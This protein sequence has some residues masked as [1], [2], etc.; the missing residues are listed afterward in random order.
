LFYSLKFLILFCRFE[1]LLFAKLL[2]SKYEEEGKFHRSGG[3]TET[4]RLP[5]K[6]DSFQYF[7]PEERKNATPATLRTKRKE[8]NSCRGFLENEVSRESKSVLEKIAEELIR[9]EVLKCIHNEELS[10]KIDIGTGPDPEPP[11]FETPL[12]SRQLSLKL[13]TITEEDI[14]PTPELTPPPR[15]N[16]KSAEVMNNA[17]NIEEE[18]QLLTLRTP[19]ITPPR[20]APV[21][22]QTSKKTPTD[23]ND[24]T[25]CSSISDFVFS[26]VVGVPTPQKESSK[27]I[28]IENFPDIQT[29]DISRKSSLHSKSEQDENQDFAGPT[30]PVPSTSASA[31]RFTLPGPGILR[32]ERSGSAAAQSGRSRSMEQ[33]GRSKSRS[34][35]DRAEFKS[36]A[37]NA[38]DAGPVS[39]LESS[40]SSSLGSAFHQLYTE[41]VSEG[42]FLGAPYKSPGEVSWSL[43]L[44]P[45]IYVS[46][47]EASEGT[48]SSPAGRSEAVSPGESR[49]N[50]L[51][52]L[53]SYSI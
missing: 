23:N 17:V 25:D 30:T 38:T 18:R 4:K 46:N 5:T 53:V 50:F 26:E 3:S 7:V 28:G 24:L 2:A 15:L 47:Q 21:P 33:L 22:V 13:S 42:E 29:P 1:Q 35:S 16:F 40:S 32:E 8:W 14:I 11:S 41:M 10:T 49:L 37:S 48:L 52:C 12:N 36:R 39:E 44:S 45:G 31:V 19:E 51:I 34:K 20:K 9:A 27:A 6:R 43:S